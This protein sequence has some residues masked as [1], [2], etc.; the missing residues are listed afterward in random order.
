MWWETSI[1]D[2]GGSQQYQEWIA[3]NGDGWII[4]PRDI[5]TQG[6]IINAW[7]ERVNEAAGQLKPAVQSL[8]TDL[9]EDVDVPAQSIHLGF[10]SDVYYLCEYLKSLEGIGV[11]H[12]ALNL[13]FNQA[14]IEVT[15]NG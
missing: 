11:N 3:R 9:V 5:D 2:Y 10:S 12:V 13:R 7:R 4:Y 15:L 1:I 8:Y 6:R 14:D